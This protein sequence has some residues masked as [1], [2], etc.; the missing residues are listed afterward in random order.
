M[1]KWPNS[2][3]FSLG[4]GGNMSAQTT[5]CI[6]RV[7]PSSRPQIRKSTHPKSTKPPFSESPPFHQCAAGENLSAPSASR[8]QGRQSRTAL[9][10][11]LFILLVCIVS[12][13]F[14]FVFFRSGAPLW[15]CLSISNWLSKSLFFLNITFYSLY[16][17][18]I[19]ILIK[20]KIFY[21]NKLEFFVNIFSPK[22]VF[23][24]IWILIFY[25][26]ILNQQK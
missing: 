18:Q 9:Q 12:G 15:I 20:Y 10:R 11:S 22:D 13:K 14:F 24:S 1:D 2:F 17:L 5:R 8:R 16:I 6:P 3:G 19:Y 23:I 4:D 21:I 26:F 25:N 7:E